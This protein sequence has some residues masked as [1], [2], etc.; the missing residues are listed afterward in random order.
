[1][2]PIE[3]R[4]QA[5]LAAL[6][7]GAPA[8]AAPL[9]HAATEA[10][11]G[12]GLASLNLGLALEQLGRLEAAAAAFETARLALPGHPEPLFRLGTLAGLRGERERAETLYRAA[13]AGDPGHV[14]ALAGLAALAEAAGRFEEAAAL[15]AR[16]RQADPEELELDVAAGRLALRRGDAAT[17]IALLGAVLEQ[18]DI[19][20][21]AASLF[22]EALVAG[23][24]LAGAEAE[25]ANRSAVDPLAANWPFATATLLRGRGRTRAALAELRA[26]DA[27]APGH[28]EVTAALGIALCEAGERVAAERTLRTAIGLRPKDIDL[29]NRLATLLYQMHR[30]LEM[31][32]LLDAAIADFGPEPTLALNR[33][34]ALNGLGEQREALAVAEAALE[35]QDAGLPGLITRLSIMAYH[36]ERGDAA[37]LRV[38]AEAI[39]ARLGPAPPPPA[40]PREPERRL[41]VGLLSGGLGQHPVGWLTLAGLEALPEPAF[42]LVGYATKR[43]DDFLGARYKARCALWHDLA[44]ADDGQIAETIRA[45]GCD[46]LIDLG[47]YGDIGRPG[48]LHRRPAPVQVKWVGTQFATTG[49]PG[50]DWMLTDR[51]ETPPGFERF[52]TERLLRLPEGYACYL[53]PPYAPEVGPLPA[54]TRG[55]VTFGCF[56]NLTKLTPRVLECWAAI[57][58]ALPESRLVLRTH[59]LGEP[60]TRERVRARFA[61]L[62]IEPGRVVLH[63]GVPHPALLAGYG[64]IDIA[65]DPFPYTGGLT[66]CEALWMGVPVVALTGDSFC[67]RHAL[68][69]LSNIGLDHWAMPDSRAYVARAIAAATDLEAL[70]TLR[71]TL[72]GCV[73]GSPLTDAPRFGRNLGTALRQAWRDWCASPDAGP[74]PR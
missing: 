73:A 24:G 2:T 21:A 11:E 6:I 47:G 32:Q 8:E 50:V 55:G 63:G 40:R 62:G 27:L 29:R 31:V 41:R 69:H 58:G 60:A 67:G 35:R 30:H 39:G 34:L 59:A 4:W 65:L 53:P 42:D 52:Y 1:V 64:D 14:T 36:P 66:V 16:A 13:L 22:T 45:D 20:P 72:R 56:N 19:H 17:A 5:G 23:H 51:W 54:F 7:R 71:A 43:R 68:S 37:G 28:P 15:I 74:P 26:A 48:V 38:A 33:A 49:L 25:L 44:E 18:R 70:A 61:A 57:L 10:G 3:P 9:L 12:G 46:I